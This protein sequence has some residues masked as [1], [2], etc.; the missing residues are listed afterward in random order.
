MTST[1]NSVFVALAVAGLGLA[2]LALEGPSFDS[3]TIAWVGVGGGIYLLYHAFGR[4]AGVAALLLFS[5]IVPSP[6]FAAI[7]MRFIA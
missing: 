2:L 5:A 6:F 7:C 4:R 3:L 1:V